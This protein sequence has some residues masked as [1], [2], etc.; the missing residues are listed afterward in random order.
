[1]LLE[2]TPL[3]LICCQHDPAL[4]LGFTV[5]VA[6]SYFCHYFFFF[7]SFCLLLKRL[8]IL[9]PVACSCAP[10]PR[11][12]A[13]L[14]TDRVCG[15]LPAP[16]FSLPGL[17]SPRTARGPL[18]G[19]PDFVSIPALAPR[20][21][22]LASHHHSF[23]CSELQPH[24]PLSHSVHSGPKPPPA[25]GEFLLVIPYLSQPTRSVSSPV[26]HPPQRLG[27]L[28][29]SPHRYASSPELAGPPLACSL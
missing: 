22:R 5:S 8:H 18:E 2:R 1:M 23:F 21:P 20:A 11:L 16:T 26:S 7:W 25:G 19:N 15:R 24:W 28:V 29:L 6:I 12:A 27:C 17:V 3:G 9:Q 10:G 4:K 14:G 13:H